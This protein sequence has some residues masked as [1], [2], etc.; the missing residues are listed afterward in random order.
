MTLP[1]GKFSHNYM[2]VTRYS[3]RESAKNNKINI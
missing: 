2:D 3:Y 1:L